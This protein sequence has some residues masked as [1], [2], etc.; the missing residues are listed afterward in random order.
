MNDIDQVLTIDRLSLELRDYSY[1]NFSKMFALKPKE[2]GKVLVYDQKTCTHTEKPIYRRYTAYGKTPEFDKSTR[3]SYMFLNKTDKD[4]PEI[5][6]PIIESLG[7]DY[8]QVLINWYEK[9]DSIE[10]PEN[11]AKAYSKRTILKIERG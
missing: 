9:G 3:K 8:N 7:A 6:K 1:I 10:L 11:D 4:V 2:L 5:F